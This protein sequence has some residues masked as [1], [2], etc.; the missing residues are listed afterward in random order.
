MSD[1]NAVIAKID[2]TVAI[3]GADNIQVGFV[4]GNPVII[5]KTM[6]EGTIG[7][8]FNVDTKLSE[9]YC[10]VNNLFRDKDRNSDPTKTG[11]FDA[12]CRVRAQPFMKVK[13]CGYF[14]PANSLDYTGEFALKVGSSFSELNGKHICEKYVSPATQ[15]AI[16]A[17]KNKAKQKV[18]KSAPHFKQHT[19]TAQFN[20]NLHR[21]N[22]GDL[23]SIYAKRHGTSA[24]Y[25]FT[26]LSLDIP[27]WQQ[28]VNK[29]AKIFPTEQWE[30]M[31]GTRRVNLFPED[32][33]KVGF[34]GSEQYRYD[35]LEELKPHLEKGMTIYGEICGYANEKLIM[36]AHSTKGLKNKAI[37]KKY[38][39][40]VEY[41]YGCTIGEK[42]FHIYRITMT[43]EA[44]ESIDFT[45]HQIEAWCKLYG[46]EAP[47]LVYPQFVYRGDKDMLVDLIDGLTEREEMLT[48]DFI[49]P[50]HV[51][52][53][54]VVRI[55][56]GDL[57]PTFLK[58][59]SFI[60]KVMEGIAKEKDDYVDAEEIS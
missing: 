5:S 1:Y 29:F 11:F 56:N 6:M 9:E 28:F 46:F 58:S 43:S 33:D 50:T 41:T 31:A 44:G 10:R 15:K 22:E 23:V 49:D 14:A 34:H 3:D 42:R 60:F 32:S 17:R 37:K 40:K 8:F 26:K 20:S 51:S 52:E 59:K 27:K 2:R 16:N 24:R 35:I 36:G 12:N 53:G 38:G 13:S 47:Y 45:H 18:T 57:S 7:V 19:D 55:D 39:D 48:E 54:V 21:V 25:G 4:L 30:Y